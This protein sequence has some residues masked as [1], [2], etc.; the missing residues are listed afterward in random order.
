MGSREDGTHNRALKVVADKS[1]TCREPTD[2]RR[3]W[4][5]P[6][7]D[8]LTRLSPPFIGR[9]L[10]CAWSTRAYLNRLC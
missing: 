7:T 8:T 2:W 9:A 6:S 1:S 10:T 5:G 3:K 4:R